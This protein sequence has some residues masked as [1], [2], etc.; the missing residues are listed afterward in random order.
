MSADYNKLSI[1][2]HGGAGRGSDHHHMQKLPFIKEALEAGWQELC[3]GK[4]AEFAVVEALAVMEGCEY[5]N[6]GYGGY[7]NVHGI[8]LLDVG[9]MRGNRD[10]VSLLNVR[11]MKYPSRVALDMMKYHSTLMTVWTH[12]LMQEIDAAPEFVK[13][14]YGLVEK[15][16]DLIAPYVSKRIKDLK[17]LEVE[18][19]SDTS[20]G[21]V[22]VV[23]RDA[24]GGLAAGTS[25]GGTGFKFNGRIGDSPIIGS[26]V[27]ADDEIGCLSTTGHGESLLLS[28][29]SA[30]TLADIRAA[31]RSDPQ[32]FK[33]NESL[34]SKILNSEIRE[35]ERKAPG[36]SGAIIV[37]PREGEPGFALSSEKVSLGL[38]SGSP[39]KFNTDR[40][41]VAVKNGADQEFKC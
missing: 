9:L 7:P 14:R 13:R 37:I 39:D 32:A 6:A 28:L 34:L 12:E 5:F 19:D 15:H 16:E 30:F 3:R 27:F 22:G 20:C 10:F 24:Y 23:A 1:A 41:F 2:L 21:T 29:L 11:R 18:S 35:F 36:Q 4:P 26:G 17:E 38:R 40:V 25:T 31:L 33:N 8:V